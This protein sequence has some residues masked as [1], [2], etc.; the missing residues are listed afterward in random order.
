MKVHSWPSHAKG[1]TRSG[2]YNHACGQRALR[3]HS[4]GRPCRHL[5][6]LCLCRAV[7]C[8]RRR[9]GEPCQDET[10]LCSRFA[11][12]SCMHACACGTCEAASSTTRVNTCA[13]L[14]WILASGVNCVC[15][16]GGIQERVFTRRVRACEGL[17][18]EPFANLRA[19]S[20]CHMLFD[21]LFCQHQHCRARQLG[22]TFRCES[23]WIAL[24]RI[25]ACQWLQYPGGFSPCTINGVCVCVC[26]RARAFESQ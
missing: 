16:H 15:K 13:C 9:R 8:R 14:R 21:S 24:A 5:V 2:D 22:G 18:F 7:L 11:F 20:K 25:S 23:V 12:G 10:M 26:V 17:G 4:S 3:A 6:R 1:P 19:Y